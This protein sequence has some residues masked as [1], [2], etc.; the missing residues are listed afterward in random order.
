MSKL[1]TQK[2]LEAK[3]HHHLPMQACPSGFPATERLVIHH[4]HSKV[5]GDKRQGIATSQG[6]PLARNPRF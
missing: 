4:Q 6:D 5:K 3:R 1:E 2:Q